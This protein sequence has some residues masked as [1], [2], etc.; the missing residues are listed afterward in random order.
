MPDQRIDPRAN[1]GTERVVVLEL[2]RD[3]RDQRWTRA[4]LKRELHDIDPAALDAALEHLW[5]M[6]V[7]C[8][9]GDAVWASP[10]T[11]HL[12]TLSMICV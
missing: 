11:Q 4:E 9:E 8:A 1:D 6:G 7:M 5:E 10:C 2:L 3:D 12:D